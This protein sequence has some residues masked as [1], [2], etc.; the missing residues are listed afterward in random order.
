MWENNWNFRSKSRF[1]F[2]SRKSKSNTLDGLIFEFSFHNFPV[3]MS[4]IDLITCLHIFC[5]ILNLSLCMC[6]RSRHRWLHGIS[7]TRLEIEGE[8]ARRRVDVI[9]RRNGAINIHRTG[10]VLRKWIN[11]VWRIK[12]SAAG[13][14]VWFIARSAG[15]YSLDADA[16]LLPDLTT[17]A[18]SSRRFV[19]SFL[20]TF[21]PF[22]SSPAP[23]LSCVSREAITTVNASRQGN[24]ARFLSSIS[25]EGGGCRGR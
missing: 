16:R 13:E 6:K 24:N 17:P 18:S 12:L 7:S 14:C 22:L 4:S 2:I 5:H 9:P 23:L 1:F 21:F 19:S 8:S 10:Q 3:L 15:Y 25:L 11:L 20:F